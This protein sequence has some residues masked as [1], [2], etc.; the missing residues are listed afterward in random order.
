MKIAISAETTIDITPEL[1]ER[2]NINIVPFSIQLGE[3]SGLDG[4]ITTD[5]IISYVNE[6]KVLPK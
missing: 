6:K 5:Q 2:F 1:K 3:V 4:E